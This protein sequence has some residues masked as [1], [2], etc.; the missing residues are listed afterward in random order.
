MT[1]RGIL[2]ADEL[3]AQVAAGAIDTV[4]VCFPD[5]QGRLMGKRV[6]GT[7]FCDRILGGIRSFFSI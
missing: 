7:Y 3:R 5:M 4:V 1:Q 6:T 2:S